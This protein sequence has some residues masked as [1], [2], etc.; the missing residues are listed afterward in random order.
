[1]K[2]RKEIDL[3]GEILEWLTSAPGNVLGKIIYQSVYQLQKMM[4]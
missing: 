3:S 4:K 2:K 1:V